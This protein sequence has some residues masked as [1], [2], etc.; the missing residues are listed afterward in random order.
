MPSWFCL[1]VRFIAINPPAE[2]PLQFVNS[3]AIHY[4]TRAMMNPF[5]RL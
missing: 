3:I 4:T 5:H 2:L 1:H